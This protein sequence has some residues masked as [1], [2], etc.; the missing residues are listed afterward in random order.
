L[1]SPA[2]IHLQEQGRLLGAGD[3]VPPQE[4]LVAHLHHAGQPLV[5]HRQRVP[6]RR[7]LVLSN[8]AATCRCTGSAF[9]FVTVNSSAPTQC[10]ALTDCRHSCSL[11]D[12]HRGA[13]VPGPSGNVQ[14]PQLPAACSRAESC[15]PTFCPLTTFMV[16][17]CTGQP[18][19]PIVALRRTT[20]SRPSV[21]SITAHSFRVRR[22]ASATLSSVCR[23]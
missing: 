12:M 3:Q 4:D 9:C 1:T 16:S 23:W 8:I 22:D 7:L 13:V 21:S 5:R 2:V 19:G 10:C 18:S 17:S 11:R 15:R 6:R 20:I 14:R